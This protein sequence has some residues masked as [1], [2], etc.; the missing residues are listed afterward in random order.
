MPREEAL[1]PSEEKL[2]PLEAGFGERVEILA[3]QWLA[4]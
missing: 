1:M 2:K 3:R 4:S